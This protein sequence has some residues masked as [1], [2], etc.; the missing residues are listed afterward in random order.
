MLLSL[1]ARPF[2]PYDLPL[3]RRLAAQGVSFDSEMT[4]THGA[5][6]SLSSTLLSALFFSEGSSPIFILR[7]G[8]AEYAAGFRHKSGEQ[9]ARIGFIAPGLDQ[10]FGEEAWSALIDAMVWAAGKRGAH[11]LNA[12]VDELSPAFAVLRRCGFAL[13]ARQDLWLRP[14]APLPDADAALLRPANEED[15]FAVNTLYANVVPRMVLQADAPPAPGHGLVYEERGRVVAFVS[16]TEGRN[17]IYLQ[18]FL[19][20]EMDHHAG[21]LHA[22]AL[23]RL[24]RAE[25]LPVYI[26]VRRYQDW[27]RVPL[28]DMGF[29]PY[30]S[31]AVMVKHTVARVEHPALSTAPSLAGAVRIVP[32]IK[33][34]G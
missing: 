5:L 9:H 24:P 3:V 15:A 2:M 17:G 10:P 27:L 20:P 11:T 26:C 13:Y 33:M 23:A 32:P 4:L 28:L 18:P 30:M 34:A 7:E 31:Q 29:E 1:E 19:H 21:A 6:S 22:A 16:V 8:E 14:P 12:E 25:R